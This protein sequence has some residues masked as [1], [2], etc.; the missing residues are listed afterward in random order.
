MVQG[1]NYKNLKRV[2]VVYAVS[3][4]R[5]SRRVAMKALTKILAG[6]IAAAVMFGAAPAAAQYYPYGGYGYGN[7]GV[8]VTIGTPGYGYGNGYNA[9]GNGYGVNQQAVVSQCTAAVQARLG[10][11]AGGRVLGISRIEPR[12]DGGLTVRGVAASSGYGGYNQQP[13]LTFKCRTDYRGY[14]VSVDVQRAQSAY[15]YTPYGA[16][17]NAYAN[18]YQASPYNTGP[19]GYSRY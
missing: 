16:A 3:R 9:Y 14:V 5:V 19:Y 6:G 8:S 4:E 11:N 12:N 7:S 10:G 13:D 2:T 17:P 18:P 1:R 15:G